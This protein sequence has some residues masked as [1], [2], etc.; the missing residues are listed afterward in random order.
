MEK[1]R[2]NKKELT[3]LSISSILTLVSKRGN[4]GVAQW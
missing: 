3:T 4:A 1:Q 2:K